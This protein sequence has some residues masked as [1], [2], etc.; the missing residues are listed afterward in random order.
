MFWN[1]IV[2]DV[3]GVPI[4][5]FPLVSQGPAGPGEGSGLYLQTQFCRLP[6]GSFL[7]SDTCPLVGGAGSWLPGGRGH[8]EG[9][10]CG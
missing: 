9:V 3:L 8:V 6:D 4:V 2:E 7:L 10:L 1:W 5:H